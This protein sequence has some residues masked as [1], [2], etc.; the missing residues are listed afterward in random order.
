MTTVF[1][2]LNFAARGEIKYD[3]WRNFDETFDCFVNCIKAFS[4]LYFQLF[5]SR[6]EVPLEQRVLNW[7]VRDTVM[8]Q[9]YPVY[10]NSPCPYL[11]H[12]SSSDLLYSL[13][14]SGSSDFVNLTTLFDNISVH[15][16]WILTSFFN[17][18]ITHS[19]YHWKKINTVY[20]SRISK[21]K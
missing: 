4:G 19:K 18:N 6:I 11:P 7:M 16:G 5:L 15:S 9:F 14:L 10:K 3:T 21:L 8:L 20:N 2:V 12:Q 1:H 17:Q 13:F